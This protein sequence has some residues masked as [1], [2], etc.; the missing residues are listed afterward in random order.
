MK[1][2]NNQIHSQIKMHLNNITKIGKYKNWTWT[3]KN[4]TDINI[5]KI[6]KYKKNWIAIL[7]RS[8]K[9]M[10]ITKYKKLDMTEH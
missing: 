8:T 4:K 6:D 9:H 5:T 1:T 7:W 2:K 3:D 10:N